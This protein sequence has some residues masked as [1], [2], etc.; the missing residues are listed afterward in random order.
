[1]NGLE[2]YFEKL[3]W[4]SRYM[5]LVAVISSLLLSLLL[6]VITAVDVFA[7]LVHTFDYIIA[8]SEVRK[9]LKIEL[10]AHTVGSIDGFLLATIL[11]IFSLGLYELFIS[12]IDEAK[13]SDQSSKVLV[14]NSLDDLKSK[15][16]KVILMILV[17]TFFE[18]SLSMS[19]NSSLDL[20]YFSLGILMVSLALYF[21]SK[22]S[23]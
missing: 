10:V 23:H 1:M 6:F 22:S 8:T 20:I 16:A 2:K 12:D 7:L 19:F 17:V 21:G 15:L 4:G 18:V 5:V 9:V 11:L 3:L 14:I 13:E